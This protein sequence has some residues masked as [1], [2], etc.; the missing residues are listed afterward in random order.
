MQ[1]QLRSIDLPR[2]YTHTV[3][4]YVTDRS[5]KL[6]LLFRLISF[7]NYHL[8][9][10]LQPIAIS[11]LFLFLIPVHLKLSP[12]QKRQDIYYTT[13]RSLAKTASPRVIW[14][15]QLRFF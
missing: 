2:N 11:S 12:T 8:I 6:L 3:L 5:H 7:I 10:I 15:Y 1:G 14:N 4:D 9:T 13:G